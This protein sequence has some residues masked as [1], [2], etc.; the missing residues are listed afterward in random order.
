ME[1][2]LRVGK[3]KIRIYDPK[4]CDGVILT[5]LLTFG[6]YPSSYFSFKSNVSET[7]DRD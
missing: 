1:T 2:R 5:H 6:Y 7:G 4:I 3:P